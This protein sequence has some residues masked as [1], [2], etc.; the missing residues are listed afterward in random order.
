MLEP[1]PNISYWI[2]TSCL[3][4]QPK[5]LIYF[6]SNLLEKPRRRGNLKQDNTLKSLGVIRQP[7]TTNYKE[8]VPHLYRLNPQELAKREVR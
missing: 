8:R 6:T 1:P 2:D 7:L 5:V 4:S 3:A